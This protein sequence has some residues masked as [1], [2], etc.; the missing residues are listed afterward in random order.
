MGAIKT[1]AAVLLIARA[2]VLNGGR[3]DPVA[4]PLDEAR[5]LLIAGEVTVPDPDDHAA[6]LAYDPKDAAP[7]TETA[8]APAARVETAAPAAPGK[9]VK[10]KGRN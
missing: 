8:Q 6:V 9:A 3:G 10:G 4:L 2:G 1:V 7:V 5:R